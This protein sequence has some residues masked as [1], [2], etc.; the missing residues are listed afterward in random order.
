MT[1]A[2]MQT[3]VWDTILDTDSANR[4]IDPTTL[5]RLLN[6]CYGIVRG[7]EDDRP[8]FV[9]A[10]TSGATFAPQTGSGFKL[11]TETNYRRVLQVYPAL[12]NAAGKPYGP[13]LSPWK[14]WEVFAMQVEDPT[15]RQIYASAYACWRA[16]TA[17]PAEVGKFNLALWPLSSVAYDYLLMVLK[18][19]TALSAAG[20]KAD[21]SETEHHYMTDMSSAIAAR[22][23]GRSEETIQQINGRLPEELQAAAARIASDMGMSS[24]RP[25]QEVA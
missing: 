2:D 6:R 11:L 9:T 15:D 20:D 14:P 13:A 8:Y 18:E 10:A 4:G 12:N 23:L 5:T 24:G 25:A 3:E 22:W 19:V 21:A 1:L 17:T 7:I 16:G